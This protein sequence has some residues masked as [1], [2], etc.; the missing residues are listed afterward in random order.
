MFSSSLF[1]L[2]NFCTDSDFTLLHYHNLES[3]FS[4]F[5]SASLYNSTVTSC[6]LAL[7]VHLIF[8]QVLF[9]HC[10]SLGQT[11][12]AWEWQNINVIWLPMSL[13]SFCISKVFHHIII[14]VR[15][16]N[17][18]WSFQ[19][20]SRFRDSNLKK[21]WTLALYPY[22]LS[23]CLLSS[24]ECFK[25]ACQ[26]LNGSCGPCRLFSFLLRPEFFISWTWQREAANLP[27]LTPSLP[28]LCHPL[29]AAL[30]WFTKGCLPICTHL[31]NY[32]SYKFV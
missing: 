12:K 6:R 5:R 19:E 32:P 9:F 26:D 10:F 18:S 15:N 25:C 22:S 23:L 21:T 4:A 8:F 1:I 29:L 20:S 13:P 11:V 16:I 7:Q 24:H 2:W 27:S 3:H 28:C 31:A 30:R 14:S 17:N